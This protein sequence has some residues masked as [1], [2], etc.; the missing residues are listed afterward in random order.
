ARRRDIAPDRLIFARRVPLDEHMARHALADLF[1][2]TFPCNAHT[3][4]NDALFAGLPLLTCAGDTFASRVSGSHL[5][6]IGLPELVTYD[7]VQYETVALR[8]AQD[9]ETLAE[10]RQ[11]LVANRATHPLFDIPAYTRALE[12]LL[13]TVWEQ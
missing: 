10:Y 7:L 5:F 1:L 2:D 8:L 9:P 3:T 11:R 6:A 12:A 13:W 4:A